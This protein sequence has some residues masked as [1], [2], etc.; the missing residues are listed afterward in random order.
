M[1]PGS[2]V[3]SVN[4]SVLK[5]ARESSGWTIQEISKK[6]KVDPHALQKWESG[7][8]PTTL[9]KLEGLANFYKRPLAA[10]FLP[11]P[12]EEPP[13]PADF[14]SLP[15]RRGQFTRKTVLVIRRATRLQSVAGE[16]TENL[17]RDNRALTGRVTLR[18]NPEQIALQQRNELGVTV[19]EQVPWRDEYQ[20]FEGWR[21]AVQAKNIYV[22]SFPMP[23]DDARGFSLSE[24][25]PLAIVVNSS[26]T[27]RARIFTLFHEYGHLLL[28]ES[29]ICIP[30]DQRRK[31]EKN[32]D[33]EGWCN[34][35]AAALLLPE[36]ALKEQLAHYDGNRPEPLSEFLS[37]AARKYKVSQ[38]AVLRRLRTLK[39]I[40]EARFWREVKKLESL[41]LLRRRG[42]RM[43]PPQSC[44][45]QNG[46][47]FVS[48]VMESK[49]RELITYRDVSDY[50]SL[51]LKYLDKVRNLLTG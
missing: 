30:R 17:G 25:E 45:R 6:L 20:A 37:Q 35:F 29:G 15:E 5:W 50:L 42:G 24:K 4:P 10:F 8:Q 43:L 1:A 14:R 26:D 2:P 32:F 21:N 46:R 9:A 16:L 33:V 11:R 19:Q 31:L 7:E 34:R 48:L 12:P 3:V 40:T 47:L 36:S 38:Q 13:R 28:R 23:I 22:F 39:L 49:E 27:P 51:D 41:T 18:E 44:I